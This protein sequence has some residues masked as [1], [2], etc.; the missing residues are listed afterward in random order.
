MC[1]LKAKHDLREKVFCSRSYLIYPCTSWNNE[2]FFNAIKKKSTCFGNMPY[3]SYVRVA[4]YISGLIMKM[5]IFIIKNDFIVL[6]YFFIVFSS[7]IY[8]LLCFACMRSNHLSKLFDSDWDTS[9]TWS[10][11]AATASSGDENRWPRSFF[12]D[13][14]E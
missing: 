3:L 12:L 10:L 9:K 14:L 8:I 5:R 11:N 4:R 1:L 6:L 13:M 2:I 7:M